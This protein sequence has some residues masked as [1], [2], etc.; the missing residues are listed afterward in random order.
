MTYDYANGAGP[1]PN[2]PLPWL[3]QNLALLEEGG[4]RGRGGGRLP[5]LGA[6]PRCLWRWMAAGEPMG[7]GARVHTCT[8][9]Q[10]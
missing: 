9:T 1:Q 10:T 2:A 6:A 3:E 5:V 7:L 4:M 8:Y